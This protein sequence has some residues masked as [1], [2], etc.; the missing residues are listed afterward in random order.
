M[1][2]VEHDFGR[3][4][5]LSKYSFSEQW[6]TTTDNVATAAPLH[7]LAGSLAHQQHPVK[8]SKVYVV[9]CSR[10]KGQFGAKWDII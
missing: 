10:E 3:T 8:E 1:T 5:Q 4:Y 2:L 7:Y 9:L 6:Q